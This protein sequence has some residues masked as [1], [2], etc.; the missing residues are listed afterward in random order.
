MYIYIYT[1]TCVLKHKII[2][3]DCSRRDACPTRRTHRCITGLRGIDITFCADSVRV[4]VWGLVRGFVFPVLSLWCVVERN[5]DLVLVC[6]LLK[7]LRELFWS[8]AAISKRPHD[9][10][11]ELCVRV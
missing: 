10:C 4:M 3:Y 8:D 5:Y 9:V 7:L 2:A 6:E 1:H 11:V